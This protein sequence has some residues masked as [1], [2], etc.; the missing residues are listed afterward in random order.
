MM[1]A[2]LAYLQN[3]ELSSRLSEWQLIIRQQRLDL[4]PRLDLF[5]HRP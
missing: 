5:V 4:V 1:A 3:L 2:M